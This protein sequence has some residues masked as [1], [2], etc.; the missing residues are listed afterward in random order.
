MHLLRGTKIANQRKCKQTNNVKTL[1]YF[2]SSCKKDIYS[3]LKSPQVE[4]EKEEEKGDDG[5]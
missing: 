1:F 5:H 3:L 4:K 2:A